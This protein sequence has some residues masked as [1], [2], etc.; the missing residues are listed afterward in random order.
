MP[1]R[2]IVK[3]RAHVCGVPGSLPEAQNIQVIPEVLAL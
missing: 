3:M 2:V 1:C